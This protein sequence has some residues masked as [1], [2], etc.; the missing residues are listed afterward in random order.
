MPKKPNTGGV[1]LVGG[2]KRSPA[3]ARLDGLT[4]KK[5]CRYVKYARQCSIDYLVHQYG[6]RSRDRY[7]ET[8]ISL[9]D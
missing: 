6:N 3:M 9:F 5:C 4:E 1:C 8:S 7:P 2:G